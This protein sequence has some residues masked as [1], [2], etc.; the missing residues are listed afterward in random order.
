[1]VSSRMVSFPQQ[2]FGYFSDEYPNDK[3]ILVVR[4]KNKLEKMVAQDVYIHFLRSALEGLEELGGEI[5]MLPGSQNRL[6]AHNSRIDDIVE[7]FE[8]SGLGSR[9]DALLC[10]VPSLQNRGLLPELAADSHPIRLRLEELIGS[11]KWSEALSITY[12]FCE[13]SAGDEFEYSAYELGYLCHLAMI[14]QDASTQAEGMKFV[15]LAMQGNPRTLFFRNMKNQRPLNWMDT[16]EQAGFW[17]RFTQQLGWMVWHISE[18][19]GQKQVIRTALN[20]HGINEDSLPLSGDNGNDVQEQKGKETAVRWLANRDENQS[21]STDDQLALSWACRNGHHAILNWLVAKWVN[22]DKLCHGA[23]IFNFII[24]AAE[25]EYDVALASLRRRGIDL[26]LQGPV[27]VNCMTAMIFSIA[28]HSN[29]KVARVLLANGAHVDAPDKTGRTPLMAASDVGLSEAVLLFLENNA[30]VNAQDAQGASPLVYAILEGQFNIA[31]IL[32]KNGADINS[33]GI[34][35]TTPLMVAA[36]EKE[37]EL[38]RL[39]LSR[40]ADVNAQDDDGQTALMI[41]AQNHCRDG[42]VALLNHGAD[43]HRQTTQRET[44]LDCA[45][46]ARNWEGVQLL[47]SVIERQGASWQWDFS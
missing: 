6:V 8:S 43:V 35:G 45:Q 33:R 17:A 11:K 14:D 47:K 29:Y 37:V 32:L 30:N 31:E 46:N 44:A 40:G 19:N 41:T 2:L 15:K 4:T 16:P 1:M 5:N 42:M 18:R 10:V 20:H 34:T 25:E 27:S 3:E 38:L 39:L 12:W 21:L 23:Y 13:R 28:L 22:I 24:W 26:D 36:D 7:C 9:E